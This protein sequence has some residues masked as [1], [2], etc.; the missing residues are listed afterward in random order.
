MRKIDGAVNRR[1]ADYKRKLQAERKLLTM[2]RR[3]VD[4]FE[5]SSTRL[6]KD[7]GIPL[8]RAAH[9]RLTDVVLEADLGLVDV[10]WKRKD[11]ETQ[12]IVELQ[13]EQSAQLKN[14]QDTMT[15]ILK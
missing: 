4:S 6:A 15:E 12:K 8:F 9:K 10:A 14:L 7:V 11:A 2:Y 3:E 13:K 5:R 1:V